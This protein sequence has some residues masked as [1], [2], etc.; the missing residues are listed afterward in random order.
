MN[1]IVS[2]L[3]AYEEELHLKMDFLDKSISR[4]ESQIKESKKSIREAKKTIDSSYNMF[5]ASQSN[6]EVETEINTLNIIIDDKNKQIDELNKRKNDISVKLLEIKNLGYEKINIDNQSNDKSDL[7]DKLK[8]TRKFMDV[9]I[10][11]AKIEIDKIITR[12]ENK[13]DM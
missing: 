9:D 11:R 1:K 3:S 10:H 6:N 5:S 2:F 7:V 8:M 4:L 12:L 13:G